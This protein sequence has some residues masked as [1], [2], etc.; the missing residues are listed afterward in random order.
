MTLMK[1]NLV[2]SYINIMTISGHHTCSATVECACGNYTELILFS[3]HTGTIV[4]CIIVTSPCNIQVSPLLAS[5]TIN[6]RIATDQTL[7]VVTTN[8]FNDHSHK[9]RASE[10]FEKYFLPLEYQ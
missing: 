10:T 2:L 6:H 7:A 1:L 4:S 8:T 5:V 9:E 3:R